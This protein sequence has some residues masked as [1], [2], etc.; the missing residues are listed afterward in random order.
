MLRAAAYFF[1]VTVAAVLHLGA[2]N[3][4]LEQHQDSLASMNQ[5]FKAR[6]AGCE[7]AIADMVKFEE[8]V[9]AFLSE[10]QREVDGLKVQMEATRKRLGNVEKIKDEYEKLEK[11]LQEIKR[12][13][14]QA[15][16]GPR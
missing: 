4:C 14:S 5:D 1:A 8:H 16:G 7:A 11:E 9:G 10:R 3:R 15:P 6:R 12:L 2:M 13:L